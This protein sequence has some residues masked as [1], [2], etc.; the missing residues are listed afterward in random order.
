MEL[1]IDVGSTNIKY[2]TSDLKDFHSVP[3]P[4]PI[5][6]E[7]N[8]YEVDPD[9]IIGLIKKII[10]STKPN[11]IYFSVQ[12]HGYVLFNKGQ[13]VINYVSWRDERGINEIPQFEINKF[14]GVDIKPNLPRLSVQTQTIQFDEFMTLGS[15]IAY[16]L[17]GHNATHISDITPT[18]Y[19]NLKENKY[20]ATPFKMP[21]VCQTVQSIGDYKGI[22]IMSP[23]GDQQCSV[24]GVINNK[25]MEDNYILNIGTASQ[26][27]CVCDGFPVGEFE[28]RPY[29]DNKTLC[30]ITRLPG[31]MA[32]ANA[33]EK[34]ILINSLF[35]SYKT[36]LD[37]L[38]KKKGIIAIG[39]GS[40]KYH[41]VIETVLKKLNYQHQFADGFDALL[42]LSNIAKG[43]KNMK[44]IGLMLSEIPHHSLP[45]LMKNSGL[46]FFIL[47]YEHGGFDYESISRIIMVSKLCGLKCIIRLANNERKDI[48]KFL[49]MGA[50]GLLLPMCNTK[51]DIAKVV[52]YSKYPPIGKRGISTMRAHTL[53]N[54]GNLMD[55]IESTNKHIEIYAQIETIEG[56]KSIK[57]ILGVDGVTGVMVG[58]NDLSADYG[59][60]ADKNAKEILSAISA[61]G[62]EAKAVNKIVFIITG[63]QNYLSKA[64]ECEFDGACIGSELNAISDYCKKIIKDNR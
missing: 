43:E 23:I 48:I 28:S 49:D 62:K 39:G 47:D 17:T 29:F 63:N 58:P 53:Y 54:P 20:D 21:F 9:Q 33:K 44:Q 14:Y 10:D 31:S 3:F 51:E 1:F 22:T 61:V 36:A 30:T 2:A 37:K 16:C 40:K 35:G 46:D 6:K 45:V 64:K 27:C 24:R 60:L 34:N 7:N 55:Y 41:D 50:N 4:A 18:G 56:V 8:K 59:C 26:L 12:M 42:G 25:E 38:P 5:I 32:I 57:E 19:F 15:F 11:A 13:R 52:E